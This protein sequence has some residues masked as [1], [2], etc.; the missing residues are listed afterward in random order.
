M[1]DEVVTQTDY[2]G[3]MDTANINDNAMSFNGKKYIYISSY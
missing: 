2:G 1:E 3:A